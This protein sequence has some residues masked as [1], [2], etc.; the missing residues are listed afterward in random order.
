LHFTNC[1]D[2]SLDILTF[3]SC[4][5]LRHSCRTAFHSEFVSR[6]GMCTMGIQQSSPYCEQ[7]SEWF[8]TKAY[9]LATK[10]TGIRLRSF[11]LRSRVN[12][13]SVS[14]GSGLF[15]LLSDHVTHEN[16]SILGELPSVHARRRQ[17]T[18]TPSVPS[19]SALLCDKWYKE[20]VAFR[21]FPNAPKN[22]D[23][24]IEEKIR[25]LSYTVTHTKQHTTTWWTEGAKGAGETVTYRK[26]LT[27]QAERKDEDKWSQR[28]VVWKRKSGEQQWST[29]H[30][31]ERRT[32]CLDVTDNTNI[33]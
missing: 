16:V 6:W 32:W 23:A 4:K 5:N 22:W 26:R 11:L 14:R 2:S 17:S 21:N 31:E 28:P 24:K 30:W 3:S 20:T 15:Q 10:T 13:T 33:F 27:Q 29:G 1:L 12:K 7:T 18:L 8:M 25:D 9:V 19:C